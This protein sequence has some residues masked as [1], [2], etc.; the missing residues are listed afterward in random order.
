MEA[1][2]TEPSEAPEALWRKYRSRC[3]QVQEGGALA[4]TPPFQLR[5]STFIH[6]KYWDA[7]R[8]CRHY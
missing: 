7:V 4:Q 2:Q 6:F 8:I 1:F 3:E 5:V